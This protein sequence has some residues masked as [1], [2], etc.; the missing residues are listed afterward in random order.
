MFDSP[1]NALMQCKNNPFMNKHLVG[2]GKADPGFYTDDY[3]FSGTLEIIQ[4]KGSGNSSRKGKGKGNRSRS[5]SRSVPRNG[6][7]ALTNDFDSPRSPPSW[8]Q[9]RREELEAQGLGEVYVKTPTGKLLSVEIKAGDTLSEV[10][11]KVR[12]IEK[13]RSSAKVSLV[14]EVCDDGSS[15]ASRKL[16]WKTFYMLPEYA[17]PQTDFCSLWALMTKADAAPE[18]APEAAPDACNT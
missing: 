14:Q 2:K 3:D 15:L 13:T 17:I 4:R 5:R 11:R 12:C 6:P 1:V 10:Q 7:W 8:E 9:D 18:A 16:L